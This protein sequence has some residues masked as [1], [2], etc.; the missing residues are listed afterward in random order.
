[1]KHIILI[2]TVFIFSA[3]AS[4]TYNDGFITFSPVKLTEEEKQI[5]RKSV[6]ARNKSYD[7]EGKMLT[8]KLSEWNYHTDATE[9]TFHDVRSS[10]YYAESLLDLDD[11]QYR[12]RAF[13]ILEKLISLQDTDPNSKSCGVWPY[14]EEEPLSTK[15]SPVDFNWADFNAVT[16]LDIYM[17]HKDKIPAG[18]LKK[19][20]DAIILAGK[21]IQKRD[22]GPGYTNIAIMGT[23]VTYIAGHLF[24]IPSFQ[25]YATKRLQKFYDYTLEKNGFSEYNSPTYTIVALDELFR[26]K[27]N[28][29]EPKNKEIIEALYTIGWETIARHYHK[30]TAQWAGPHSRTYSTI[31]RPQFYGILNSA[32]N[33]KIDLGYKDERREV[34]IKHY[35]PEQ[36]LSYF[37]TPT[38]PRVQKDVFEN[39]E[40]Q[41]IGACYL[42]DKYA[43]SS[44][45]RSSMWNQRRPFLMYWGSMES[46]A[47]LQ[48]RLLH[49]F[50]DLSTATYFSEQKENTILSA[51]NFATDGGDKH[52]NIDILENGKFMA[53]DLRLRFEFGN[54]DVSKLSIPA[55]NDSPV[56]FS[57]GGLY[58]N[59][60][61]FYSVF[62]KYKGY[63]EKGSDNRKSWI[64]FVLYSGNEIEI[65]LTSIDVAALGFAFSVSTQ[66]NTPPKELVDYA[67]KDGNLSA[68][69]KDLKINIP[70]KPAKKPRNL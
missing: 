23:Y 69:W 42:T 43:L 27:R 26:M 8:T 63:W 46:P 24:N 50:Y 54:T 38:Y 9:G 67:V 58:F 36:L 70:V 52:I 29:V 19:M 64:D 3:C 4:K 1:M 66:E 51:I 12:Q 68:K 5:V 44:V 11:I 45:N 10:F 21:A 15:K 6:E 55:K 14:Y 65:D 61:L 2:I 32:S 62:G 57:I 60:Q 56:M 13:D 25:E 7:A 18:L 49:D 37:L 34:K 30:P 28:I 48:V 53:K 39:V 22:V 20:E 16:L 33:G 41:I 47:Y 35:I 17:G 59:I 31:I 40:P